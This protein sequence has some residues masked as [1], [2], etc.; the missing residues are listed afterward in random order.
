MSVA[1]LQL[2]SFS[3]LLYQIV[4]ILTEVIGM[5]LLFSWQWTMLHKIWQ[6]KNKV[7]CSIVRS[8]LTLTTTFTF[9]TEL[10]GRSDSSRQEKEQ[11]I[12][13][14]TYWRQVKCCPLIFRSTSKSRPNNIR[15]GKMSVRTSVRPSTNSFFDFNEIWCIGRGRWV[16]HD[17]MPYGRIQGQGHEP[18]KV[19]IPSIFKT[20]L[21]RH[22][23]WG[24]ANDH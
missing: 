13:A 23:Q 21:L 18:L 20:Y 7:R 17:G 1:I 3:T 8:Y 5:L 2:I 12:F 9:H 15:G 6:V 11:H 24:L 14:D 4:S 16:M 19:W 10:N 22:L